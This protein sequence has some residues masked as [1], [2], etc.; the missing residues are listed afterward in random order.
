IRPIYDF[1]NENFN[2]FFNPFIK[3]TSRNE[4]ISHKDLL[5]LLKAGDLDEYRKAIGKHV[6]L[7]MNLIQLKKAN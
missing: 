5:E 2:D 6:A 1:I 3:T 4:L 7:Y